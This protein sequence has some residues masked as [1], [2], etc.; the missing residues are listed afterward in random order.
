[1]IIYP[2]AHRILC[3]F[4]TQCRKEFLHAM[5][6]SQVMGDF[7]LKVYSD[8]DVQELPVTPSSITKK[9]YGRAFVKTNLTKHFGSKYR[10]PENDL[11]PMGEKLPLGI[12]GEAYGIIAI[13]MYGPNLSIIIDC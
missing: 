3:L 4:V 6:L 1:M 10:H 9:S 7:G 11:L 8:R 2:K 5:R 12:V 13:C